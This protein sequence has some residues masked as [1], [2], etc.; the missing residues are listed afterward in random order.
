MIFSH[1]QHLTIS[2][3]ELVKSQKSCHS[4]GGG[5]PDVVPAK[6]G[7]QS[8]KLLDSRFRGNDNLRQNLTLL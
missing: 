3:D 1:K 2:H 7:N 5:S 8:V 6:A 4:R